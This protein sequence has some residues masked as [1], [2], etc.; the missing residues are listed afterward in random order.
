[1]RQEQGLNVL[2]QGYSGRITSTVLSRLL[3]NDLEN[4]LCSIFGKTKED[5][6]VLLAKLKI[7]HQSLYY[8]M[9]D[10]RIDF[11]VSGEIIN[12][13]HVPLT[14]VVQGGKYSFSGRCS[15]IPKVC[16]VDLYL[17]KSYSKHIG[18][19]VRQKFSISV[20]KLIKTLS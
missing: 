8:E 19:K 13:Q 17:S 1:M 10:Q 5:V 3:L 15:T 16:G 20:K 12:H 2:I 6:P 4:C 7:V 18:D 11:E 9:F 14:Y